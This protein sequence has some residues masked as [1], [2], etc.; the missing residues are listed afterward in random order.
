MSDPIRALLHRCRVWS[1]GWFFSAMAQVYGPL[2]WRLRARHRGWFRYAGARVYFPPAGTWASTVI[3]SGRAYEP[4]VAALCLA[5]AKDETTVFDVGANIGISALPLL[6]A[7]PN[8][9]VVSLE[10]SPNTAPYLARTHAGC[11]HAGRWE[12]VTR[13]ASD[14]PA[15]RTPFHVNSPG[16]DALDGIRDTRRATG[17]RT[18]D[19][20]TTTLDQEWE[21]RH[22]PPV[23]LLKV[24]VEGAETLVFAGARE[25]LRA[26]RPVILCEWCLANL[27]AYDTR[28]TWILDFAAEFGYAVF[29]LPELVPAND[30][31]VF[32]FQLTVRENLLLLPRPDAPFKQNVAG[33]QYG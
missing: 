8:L 21:S 20:E 24:D 27:I 31:L 25:L 17:G 33:R 15:K 5:A 18:V 29:L 13:A 6:M 26:C 10:P 14:R 22:R 32:P 7:R 4:E 11:A 23:S 19:V 12:L 30:P 3:L 2:W 28:P 1:T 16:N 9:R